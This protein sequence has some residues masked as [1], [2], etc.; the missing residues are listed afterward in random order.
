MKSQQLNAGC[1][2]VCGI[3]Q[4]PVFVH[5]VSINNRTFNLH[6]FTSVQ[7]YAHSHT[8][9]F[10]VYVTLYMLFSIASEVHNLALC[11]SFFLQVKHFKEMA[12][13]ELTYCMFVELE[14]STV[15]V[16]MHSICVC[17][18]Y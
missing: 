1:V 14:R 9:S 11:L 16:A 2:F 7:A 12:D 10:M 5:V 3:V 15:E 18:C 13:T 17:V 6:R 8:H 4:Y